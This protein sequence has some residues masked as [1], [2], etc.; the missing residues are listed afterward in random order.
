ML[1]Y[2]DSMAITFNTMITFNAG[3]IFHFVSIPCITDQGGI[4]HR[5]GDAFG[6]KSFLVAPKAAAGR[7]EQL[8]RIPLA[9]S[10]GRQS[11]A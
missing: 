8:A 4:L 5:I 3:E 1:I 10:R 7:H 2:D 9:G 11:M 6:K